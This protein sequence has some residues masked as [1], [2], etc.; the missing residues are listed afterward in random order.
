MGNRRELKIIGKNFY[1]KSVRRKEYRITE[2]WRLER[3]GKNCTEL[4][5]KDLERLGKH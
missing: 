2:T 5:R 1:E 4:Q 3:V